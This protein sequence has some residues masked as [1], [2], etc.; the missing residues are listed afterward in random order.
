MKANDVV[1]GTCTFLM[2]NDII[3]NASNNIRLVVQYFDEC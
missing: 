3:N 2:I 1:T